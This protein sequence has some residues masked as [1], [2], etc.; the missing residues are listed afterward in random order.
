MT[1]TTLSGAFDPRSDIALYINSPGGS[2]NAGLAIYDTIQLTPHD[3]ATLVTGVA[4]DTR[5]GPQVPVS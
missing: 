1:T 2:I 3:V 5:Q 4:S